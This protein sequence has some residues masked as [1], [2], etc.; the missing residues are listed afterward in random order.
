MG[1]ESEPG[2]RIGLAKQAV[3]A[4]MEGDRV[5]QREQRLEIPSVGGVEAE[6]DRKEEQHCQE[7][8]R[9]IQ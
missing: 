9:V 3:R 1:F 5:R 6:T 4:R 7:H 2:I 8:D